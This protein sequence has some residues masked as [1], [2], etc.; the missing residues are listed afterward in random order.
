M[1]VP[2]ILYSC[3]PEQTQEVSNL[4]QDANI[5]SAICHNYDC[6]VSAASCV[7]RYLATQQQ[8]LIEEVQ[9]T[10]KAEVSLSLDVAFVLFSAYLVFGPMQLGF[11]LL[12]AGAIRSKNSM[13]VL[14]KNILD[15]CTG[16]IGFYLFGYA[17]AFGHEAKKSSNG[18]IGNWNFALSFTTKES[19][20]S[21]VLEFDDDFPDE[22]WHSWF[23]QFSLCAIATTIVS[24][25]VAERCTF[26]AYLAY[27]FFISA[28]VYPVVAHWVWSPDGWLSA[29]NTYVGG[30]YALILR[31][32]AID[33]A[34]AGVVHVTGGMAALMGA[35]II[36][37]RIGRF[38]ASGKVNEIKGHS[39]TL[40]VMG[41]FLM[42]FGYYGFAPGANLSVAT[43]DA[44][45]VVSRVAVTTTL[46]AA[47]AGLT[48]LFLRYAMSSTWD[49]VLVCNGCL[50][51]LVAITAGCAVVEP[52]AA[53]LCGSAAA[54]VFVGSDYLLLYKL[55]IDDPVSA[56]SM[57]LFCGLWGLF[58]PG[59]LAK[60]QYMADVYGDDGLA[61]SVKAAGKYGILYGGHGQVL[62]CQLIEA[63]AIC[64]WV[65]LMMGTFFYVFKAA[66]RLRVPVDQEL[67]GQ[68]VTKEGVEPYDGA[69]GS[70]GPQQGVGTTA[71]FGP[72]ATVT[73]SAFY[74]NG[75]GEEGVSGGYATND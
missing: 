70:V 61:D 41:T 37:P 2:T 54:L 10:A 34:G 38:D 75:E 58:F 12:C 56:V 71:A 21:N 46:S 67:A 65:G 49:T 39:A 33:F 29:F 13:N 24:G 45:V 59:L 8:T 53:V 47:S 35:W 31:S 9:Q 30:R 25:A 73:T 7:L 43:A 4:V 27:S 57:H 68:D 44:A 42:W 64:L 15:A 66:K 69:G 18:F 55:K 16:A 28:F 5:A 40:V 1:S 11:A 6:S 23:F 36:G 14:M 3:T 20:L 60:P 62:L 50:G 74:S 51:G 52:W 17:F 26:G 48:T 19:S 72:G 22:G 32:G 63:V